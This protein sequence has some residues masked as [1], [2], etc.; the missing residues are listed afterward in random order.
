MN[1]L[2]KSSKELFKVWVLSSLLTL[3]WCVQ[4][5]TVP[6]KNKAER[7]LENPNNM[8]DQNHI[9]ECKEEMHNYPWSRWISPM[10]SDKRSLNNI[11]YKELYWYKLPK[12]VSWTFIQEWLEN[13]DFNDELNTERAQ[14]F[15]SNINGKTV[16]RFYLDWVLQTATYVS[17]WTRKH[18]TSRWNFTSNNYLD[19]YHTSS[20]SEYR[21]AVMPYAIHVVWWI[22]I[23]GSTWIINWYPRSH[24]CIRT[25]LF[26]VKS[27]YDMIED[28]NLW[29]NIRININNIY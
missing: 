17:V 7:I 14:I 23:H 21:W 13:F 1:L 3:T 24:W 4:N 11:W 27:I 10:R 20:N 28:N 19:K 12:N 6:F 26:F 29:N 8:F 25:P 18:K 15:V 22:R 2:P 16:L 5:S 9:N